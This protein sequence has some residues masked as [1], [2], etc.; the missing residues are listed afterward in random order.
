MSVSLL[1]CYSQTEIRQIWGY[2]HFWMIYLSEIFLRQ[3]WDIGSLAFT[4]LGWAYVL[5]FEFLCDGL[6]FETSDLFTVWLSLGQLLRPYGLV[7]TKVSL[8][9]NEQV[10]QHSL[11][12]ILK[13]WLAYNWQCYI[14]WTWSC[15]CYLF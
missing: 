3:S 12:Y 15:Y 5:T 14:L 2:L 11:S 1:V 10:R 9:L 7:F 4:Q 8:H 6:N 13:L